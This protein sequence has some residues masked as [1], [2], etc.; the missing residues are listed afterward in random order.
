MFALCNYLRAAGLER[1]II[2]SDAIAPAGLGPG[3]YTLGNWKLDI[4][5]DLVAYAPD[6]S[7]LVGSA[8]SLKVAA[9]RLGA[10]GFDDNAVR[11]LTLEN[12]RRATGFSL[13]MP[14]DNATR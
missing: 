7:H 9:D 8:V 3:R 10:A 2:V 13:S 4:G 5:P 11:Q 14:I 6:R 12:P 1:C